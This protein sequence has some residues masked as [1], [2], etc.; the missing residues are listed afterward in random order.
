MRHESRMYTH[1]N[2]I[3]IL[4]GKIQKYSTMIHNT[5]IPNIYFKRRKDTRFDIKD[6]RYKC[7]ISLTAVW[8]V[9]SFKH[10]SIWRLK[11]SCIIFKQIT[12]K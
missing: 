7:T 8:D 1:H 4:L 11:N 5:R 3:M 2:I 6:S 10:F 9:D 12:K